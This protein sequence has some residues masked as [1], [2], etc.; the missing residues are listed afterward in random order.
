M[1]KLGI[2]LQASKHMTDP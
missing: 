2:Y 1:G